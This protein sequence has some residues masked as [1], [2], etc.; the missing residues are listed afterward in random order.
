[1][2]GAVQQAPQPDRQLTV[3]MGPL[4]YR[5]ALD[6]AQKRARAAYDGLISKEG[7]E[8]TMPLQ[9][10]KLA[11][12]KVLREAGVT[13]DLAEA[14][15]EAIESGLAQPVVLPADLALL[16]AEILARIDEIIAARLDERL[17]EF[18]A[19]LL[20]VMDA[21]FAAFEI[22]IDK[23]LGPLYRISSI[24]LALSIVSIVLNC[25]ILSRL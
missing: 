22:C 5:A 24:S 15:A 14:H 8:M 10:D 19:E 6:P 18:K 1:M 16:K 9:F 3:F 4:V 7:D 21:K 13:P 23:K 11:Y 17:K 2:E 12:L 25:I 20:A